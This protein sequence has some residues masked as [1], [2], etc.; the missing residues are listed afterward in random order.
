MREESVSR[1]GFFILL[2]IL[3]ILSYLVLKPMLSYIVLA[4][5]FAYLFNPAFIWLCKKTGK[6]KISAGLL[7]AF[8]IFVFIIPIIFLLFS[9][10][11]QTAKAYT[12]FSDSTTYDYM[13]IGDIS[14]KIS[15]WLGYD[16]DLQ[17]L[18]SNAI[19]RIGKYVIEQKGE[20]LLTSISQI[21]LGIFVMF[22]VMY[23]LFK[24][25]DTINQ[26][27]KEIIPLKKH[28]K[29]RL[30]SEIEN[31]TFA[32]L[33]GQILTAIIQG[34]LLGLAFFVS[35][36]PNSLLWAFV[37]IVIAFIPFVGTPTIF[38]PIS[39]YLIAIDKVVSGIGILLFGFII[40]TNVD[41][42]VKPKIIGERARAHPVIVLLGVIGGL[43]LLGF[44]GLIIGPLILSLLIVILRFYRNEF[45]MKEKN[46]S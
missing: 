43:K 18:L 2:G 9:L 37:A 30:F 3:L 28:H 35:G 33:Y 11:N 45:A 7:T 32:V 8:I 44:V 26:N 14:K 23:Y 4:M 10:V 22:F 17:S 19:S 36:V 16:I 1:Y 41:N 46:E 29:T 13:H 27:L 24:G 42:I 6:K 12:D 5:I 20:A 39:I 21:V 34:S 25:G 31:M 15:S 40:V 38:V